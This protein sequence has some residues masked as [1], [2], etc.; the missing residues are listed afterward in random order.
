MRICI[1]IR[2][3]AKGRSGLALKLKFWS[4][5]GYRDTRAVD[6]QNEVWRFKVEG[7]RF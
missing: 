5:P 1:G 2:I 3:K 7:Q 6:P 4:Y